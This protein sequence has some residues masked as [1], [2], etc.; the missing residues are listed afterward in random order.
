M[1]MKMAARTAPLLFVALL[2]GTTVRSMGFEK[3]IEVRLTKPTSLSF[4]DKP[5]RAGTV[6]EI[7]S[8]IDHR[9]A[10]GKIFV[11][12]TGPDGKPLALNLPDDAV[13]RAFPPRFSPEDAALLAAG[14]DAYILSTKEVGPAPDHTEVLEKFTVS[15]DPEQKNVAVLLYAMETTLKPAVMANPMEQKKAL[16]K[17]GGKYRGLLRDEITRQI[18]G[19]SSQEETMAQAEDMLKVVQV[20]KRDQLTLETLCADVHTWARA[21]IRTLA[22][23][24]KIAAAPGKLPLAVSV[25]VDKQMVWARIENRSDRTFHQCAITARRQQDTEKVNEM[26]KDRM[27]AAGLTAL[28]GVSSETNSLNDNVARL[29]IHTYEMESGG[30]IF[31]PTLPP[32]S[33]VAFPVSSLKGFKFTK[34]IDASIWCDEGTALDLPAANLAAAQ[35]PFLD[36]P[37][38]QRS[39]SNPLNRTPQS[40][41]LMPPNQ[42]GLQP[43]KG[44]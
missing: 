13:E 14:S 8:V 35:K 40:R 4:R 19:Q 41:G 2:L 12:T 15:T 36:A 26:H 43:S 30:F 1:V 32:R 24:R 18:F 34:N 39:S 27:L 37:R 31:L 9:T 22:E 29:E 44:L 3:G 21:D 6:G 17:F 25:I 33:I 28:L 23:S 38:Q 42:G 10:E 11:L 5:F 16:E 20:A 7:F